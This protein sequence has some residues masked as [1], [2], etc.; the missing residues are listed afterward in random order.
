[1]IEKSHSLYVQICTF[2]ESQEYEKAIRASF[3]FL[4]SVADE[5]MRLE[6]Y[7]DQEFDGD[8]FFTR[9]V[10]EL[11]AQAL[12]NEKTPVEIVD[13]AQD[14]IMD[15]EGMEAYCEYCLCSFEHVHEAIN[16][17]LADE[18]TYL[19]ELDRQLARYAMDYK[20][21]VDTENFVDTLVLYQY[22]ELGK[23][24][25]KKVE[26]LRH[27]DREDEANGIFEEYKY[28]SALCSYRIN[29]FIEKGLDDE[30]LNE[31]NKTISV[32]GD[33]EFDYTKEWHLQK[34]AILEKRN[35]KEGIIDEYVRL[36]RQFLGKKR[37]YFD[38]LKELLPKT[39]W[40]KFVVRLFEDIPNV[41]HDDCVEVCDLIIEEK[42]YQCLLKVLMSNVQSFSRIEIFKKY[43]AYMS[44]E[45]QATY[46][47][48]LIE[49]IW[50]R[51][52]Y[53]KSK[54][55]GYI[56]DDIKKIY[57]C[58]EVSKRLVLEFIEEIVKNYGNRPALIHL[59]RN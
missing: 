37:P 52:S 35:D 19:A 17:R 44:E 51:L 54:N 24:L 41:S 25:I 42:K 26:Y 11:L 21:N 38:K 10:E 12:R 43:S 30:D 18:K 4:R 7:N 49:D 22:E 48:Y 53:A 20:R 1:M 50:H 2:V 14:E 36:F 40:D 58:G 55:Y 32:Y 46:T 31:I 13:E 3:D 6:V 5:Y 39:D 34:I 8:D 9:N 47:N 28:V 56:V 57:A 16:Y 33:D 59:L 27:Y 15:I 29:E 45:D 23:L